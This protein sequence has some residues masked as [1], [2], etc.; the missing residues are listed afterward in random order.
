MKVTIDNIT[1]DVAPGT[2]IMQA[3]RQ[4]GPHIAPPAM[5]YYEP[6]KASGG[7]SNFFSV[8]QTHWAMTLRRP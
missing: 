8:S 6:L 7:K 2:T 4:I 1:V 3:A 5:C